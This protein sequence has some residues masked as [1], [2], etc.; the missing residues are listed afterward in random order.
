[1]KESFDHK[2]IEARWQK[3]WADENLYETLNTAEGKENY[4]LLVEYPYPSGNLH[5]GH[6]Y[7]FAVPDIFARTLRMQGK[8]VLF[9]IGFDSFGLPA[10]N[11]AIKHG[12]DPK[13]WTYDNI[14]TMTTQL[15]SMG[16]SF[17]WSRK[18][19]A[20]DPEYHK[21][22]QWLFQKFFEKGL[23]Y[24]KKA[25]VN[26]CESCKTVLANEQVV[27]GVCERCKNP[28]T[29]KALEQWFVK[30]T[31]YAERLL[32]N[33]DTL[34]WPEEIKESQ[35]NWIGKSEGAEIDFT[36]KNRDEKVRVF[37]TRP[38][39]LYG[40]T[41]MVLAPEHE[42]VEA[43]KDAIENWDEIAAYMEKTKRKTELERTEAKEK[44]GI[45]LKGIKAINPGSKEEIPI[46]IADYVLASYGTGAIMAVP[47]H[48]ERDFEFAKKMELPVTCVIGR[49]NSHIKAAG[50]IIRTK[51]GTYLLE[52][53]TIDDPV[54]PKQLSIFGG[55]S[56]DGETAL[57]C[58]Q[59]ELYEE[60]QLDISKYPVRLL[61]EISSKSDPD[62]YIA[63]FEINEVDISTITLS[64]E[65]EAVVELETLEE[66]LQ[67]TEDTSFLQRVFSGIYG[68]A[69]VPYTGEGIL[70][71]SD[72]FNQIS[73]SDAKQK[74]T[75]HVGGTMTTKYKLRDWLV[76]RQRY[77]GC[78]IPVV[79]DPEGKA[80]L[81]PEEH[82][83]WTLPEDVD[84]TPTGESPLASSRELKK[85]TERI[86][87]KGWT[88]EYDTM[89]TFVD[90]SWYFLR[91]LDP[92]NEKEFSSLEEQ[93]KWMPVDRYSGGAEHTTM[94]VLYS[95]FFYKA[96]FDMG[97]VTHEEPYTERMNR[98]LILGP[99]GSKMS[100]SK[101]N[102]IDP[103]EH[104]ERV[105]ADTVKMYLA[106]IGPFYETGQY[107][108][109]LGGIAGIRRFLERVWKFR[110]KVSD[111]NAPDELTLL[112]H[113]SIK[114]VDEDVREFKFNTAISQ[115]MILV[116]TLEKSAEVPRSA[117]ETLLRLLAPF[118]P[119]LAEELWEKLGHSTSIHKEAWPKYDESVLKSATVTVAVQV[120]GK[121]KGT[122]DAD[123]NI[124]KDAAFSRA[125]ELPL[126]AKWLEGN[127]VAREIY[128]PRR[129]VN[130]VLD[131][132]VDNA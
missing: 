71:N 4:Y 31:D 60:L 36:L 44:T 79:Y 101:G 128:V 35:R 41:Y 80:H 72:M 95:R 97:L 29:Q 45:E 119:H 77:W 121:T 114:K 53:R 113:Q 123:P 129:L 59:R 49:P 69:R 82:L 26:W 93:K 32:S 111:N 108:W 16:N 127:T 61:G 100:K 98:G 63:L 14:A 130:F 66:S 2:T 42:L 85:R 91:Y 13:K 37:T 10:E 86:F 109:D 78:P 1:M 56:E 73:S 124:E 83:P 50:A 27:Q 38:D 88:P 48:D 115:L 105:G 19:V 70:C 9:P 87:G 28:V 132:D 125:R 43:L 107:P 62:R 116:N 8:N 84:F 131:T 52:R 68:N 103:G 126:V 3:K 25:A 90:S 11:A 81:V 12:L 47:A 89:D 15:E 118:A 110:E 122:F 58:L 64:A 46:F 76:S 7:A 74:I 120:N 30:I 96:L 65:S 92:H 24:K 51:E 112:L 106:F 18:V 99:D 20:S 17:D 21:W 57:E 75:E 33:L 117:Y 22:T 94:H 5:I 23:A 6:W 54:R 104:V 40:A 55:G 102:V 34:N 39:T 67:D